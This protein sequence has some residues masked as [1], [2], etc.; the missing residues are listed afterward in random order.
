MV[1]EQELEAALDGLAEVAAYTRAGRDTFDSSRER[2]FALAYSWV[3][4]GS[5]LKQYCRLKGIPHGTWP[6]TGPVRM[7]DK[8]AYQSVNALDADVLWDTCTQN[9]E[10]LTSGLQHIKQVG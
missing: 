5:C 2:Q 8:L 9:T 4:V 6:F 1:G 3:T 7:R 10:E